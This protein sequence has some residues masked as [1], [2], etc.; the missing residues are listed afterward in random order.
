ME[1]LFI[2]YAHFI[3]IILLASMLVTENILLSRQLEGA[4][5]KTLARIDGLYGLGAV[6]TLVAGLAL[7]VWVGKPK[8]FYSANPLFHAKVGLFVL[9]AVM[10]IV[11]TFFFARNRNRINEVVA[12]PSGVMLI[13]RLELVLLLILPLLAVL[14]A[15][16]IGSN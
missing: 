11:P 13:K 2:R 9:I 7:W 3:G 16:G 1:E 10:S 6:I 15:R 8:E 4:T 5:L 14:M 12:V